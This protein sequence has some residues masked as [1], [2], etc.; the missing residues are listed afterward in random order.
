[1]TDHSTQATSFLLTRQPIF[2]AKKMLWGYQLLTK[3]G[4]ESTAA[5]V[6]DIVSAPFLGLQ[7][8]VARDKK[9]MVSFDGQSIMDDAPYALPPAHTVVKVDQDLLEVEVLAEKLGKLRDEGFRLCL[10]VPPGEDPSDLALAF[11]PDLLSYRA[12][13]TARTG[14]AASQ[15][16]RARH[17]LVKHIPDNGTFEAAKGQGFT[18]FQGPFFKEAEIVPDRKLTSHQISRFNLFKLIE[19]EDPDFNALSDAI[20]T[21]VSISF[22]LLAYLNT[23]A[24]GFTQKVQ[25]IKQAITLLGWKKIKNW[26]RAV[27]LSD[28]AK[29]GDDVPEL[30]LLSVQRGKFL[31]GVATDYDFWGFDPGN[32]FLLGMFSLL[33]ALLGMPMPRIVEF[34]PLDAKLRA[35]LCRDPNN[36]YLPLFALMEALEDADWGKLDGVIQNLSLDPE[37]I[38]AAHTAAMEWA[39][40]FFILP[41]N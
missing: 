7:Q 26:L 31:E 36:E 22:R 16:E 41:K 19:Q 11:K 23:A 8:I 14:K 38:K 21:D 35:A 39:N 1:M 5:T 15:A 32:L 33:D 29:T 9:I 18:L 24:F 30:L 13:D 12:L 40:A 25:S 17:F 4:G 3:E 37:K 2:D 20:K 28:M 10:R 27:L 34:L 6:Q